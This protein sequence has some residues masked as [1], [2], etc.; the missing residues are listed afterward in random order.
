MRHRITIALS[1]G[2][3]IC[4]LVSVLLVR[5]SLSRAAS[6]A[7]C[8]HWQIVASPTSPSGP[9]TLTG[10]SSL[11][12]D[13]AWAVGYVTDNQGGLTPVAEHWDGTQWNMVPTPPTGSIY[14]TFLGVVALAA[15]NVWAVGGTDGTE[16]QQTLV[17]HWNGSQWS[18]V[19]SPNG[20]TDDMLNSIA[21]VSATD[22]WAVGYNE[23]GIANQGVILHWDG[24][25]WSIVPSAHSNYVYEQLY[26]VTALSST[27]AWAVGS[28]SKYDMNGPLTFVEHWNGQKWSQVFSP[29]R[30]SSGGELN[31]VVTLS[32][33]DIWAAGVSYVPLPTFERTLVEHW[34]GTKWSIVRSPNHPHSGANLLNDVAAVAPDEVWTVGDYTASAGY[35]QPLSERWNGSAW[36][37]V[38]T[39]FLSAAG[40]QLNG[41]AA[42]TTTKQVW[43]VGDYY[44]TQDNTQLPLIESYC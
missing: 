36:K 2:A 15:D 35:P 4:L 31:S 27:D 10:V 25:Q 17:E 24:T 29:N 20:G 33:T 38:A 6:P 44:S 34:D 39:P 8:G 5:A 30:S 9:I 19:P 18:V 12:A 23:N 16:N 14:N 7:T 41:V 37:E 11:S 13:D 26:G 42:L 32:A 28:Y 22:I 1:F 43:A 21:A 3:I 40:D